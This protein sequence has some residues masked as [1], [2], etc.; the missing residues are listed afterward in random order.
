MNDGREALIEIGS[1]KL[2]TAGVAR[3]EILE[4]LAWARENIVLLTNKFKE[5]NP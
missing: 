2:L 1:L 4:V 5:Y 3:R